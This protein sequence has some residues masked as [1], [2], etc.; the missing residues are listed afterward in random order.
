MQVYI[1][2]L[3]GQQPHGLLHNPALLA[4]VNKSKELHRSGDAIRYP[5]HGQIV[6]GFVRDTRDSVLDAGRIDL[7]CEEIAYSILKAGLR[8][9]ELESIYPL[10]ITYH[11]RL[12][13][14]ILESL[15]NTKLLLP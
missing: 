9:F 14:G 11:K 10:H 5:R 15:H 13:S 3:Q 1:A 12:V 2:C 4:S 7:L 6:V 8:D